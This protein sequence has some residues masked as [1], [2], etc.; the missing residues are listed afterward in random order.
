L[1]SYAALV[2]AGD[3]AALTELRRSWKATVWFAQEGLL[4]AF[5]FTPYFE[6][7]ELERLARWPDALLLWTFGGSLQLVRGGQRLS[8]RLEPYPSGRLRPPAAAVFELAGKRVPEGE[9]LDLESWL[10]AL[11]VPGVKLPDPESLWQDLEVVGEA[12]LARREAAP[13]AV[14]RLHRI[15]PTRLKRGPRPLAEAAAELAR[16]VGPSASAAWQRRRRAARR[17]WT[18]A[19][20][21]R[22]DL[23]R[24][25][26][27]LPGELMA[28]R[29]FFALAGLEAEAA[30]GG[31]YVE[32]LFHLAEHLPPDPPNGP[33][34]VEVEGETGASVPQTVREAARQ[35]VGE[36]GP[37][38]PLGFLDANWPLHLIRLRGRPSV[39]V[40]LRLPAAADAE[41]LAKDVARLKTLANRSCWVD[42]NEVWLA[43]HGFDLTSLVG[44]AGDPPSLEVAWGVDPG[45]RGSFRRPG[46]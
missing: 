19:P 21:A 31:P 7:G 25:L 14:K 8:L 6:G 42:E 13:A 28:D 24:L 12:W 45:L 20:P 17:V 38:A 26:G 46:R 15:L 39:A 33:P 32:K 2:G 23:A 3:E 11:G 36:G 40:R 9:P 10:S 29:W 4:D 34:L 35:L 41:V 37:A 22:P 43:G 27:H 44:L 5:D 30:N 1:P 16:C 18:F